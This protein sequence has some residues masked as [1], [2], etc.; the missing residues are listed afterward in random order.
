LP[1]GFIT[2][3]NGARDCAH[4]ALQASISARQPNTTR[5][6]RI[7]TLQCQRTS[8][9]FRVSYH[10]LIAAANQKPICLRFKLLEVVA[11]RNFGRSRS[12]QEDLRKV[13]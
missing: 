13:D 2:V 8:M 11:A 4:K 10:S 6:A 1:V 3:I 9:R 5:I 7:L 12:F